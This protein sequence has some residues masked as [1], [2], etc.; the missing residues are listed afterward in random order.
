MRYFIKG[1]FIEET[2]AGK[3]FEEIASWIE[4]V[5][6]P[7]L[8]MLESQIQAGKVSGGLAAGER[9]AY[10]IVDAPSNV[11]VGAWLRSFPFWGA[12]TWTVIPLHSAR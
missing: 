5:I 10:L 1:E 6:H 3:S 8:E 11:E 7:S 9:V 12:L 4:M 2:F